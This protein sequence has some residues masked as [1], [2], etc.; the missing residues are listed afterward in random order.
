MLAF[1]CKDGDPV[2]LGDIVL[3]A[4]CD[5]GRISFSVDAPDDVRVL[6]GDVVIREL[7]SA[8]F[9]RVGE[10]RWRRNGVTFTCVDALTE[11]KICCT[12]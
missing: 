4:R 1:H 2:M 12:R 8:G 3:Y 9:E 5:H 7:E 6:R 11:A 10:D